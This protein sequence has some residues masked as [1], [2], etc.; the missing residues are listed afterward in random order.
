MREYTPP[1]LI[2]TVAKFQQNTRESIQAQLG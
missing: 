2:D 1:E